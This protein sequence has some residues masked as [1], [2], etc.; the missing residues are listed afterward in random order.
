MRMRKKKHGAER[1]EKCKAVLA[2][3]C[4]FPV[5]DARFDFD[6]EAPLWLE[7]GAGK[8]GF[9]REMAARNPDVCFYALERSADCVVLAAEEAVRTAEQ[10]PTDNLRFVVASADTLAEHFAEGSIDRIYLNFSD[11]WSK[12][13]YYKR[14][15]TYRG[16]L[17]MYARLLRAGGLLRFKT[18]NVG[19]FDFTLEELAALGYTPRIVTRDL[20]ASCYKEGNVMTEYE[21]R[22]VGQGVPICMLEV[23][24]RNTQE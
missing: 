18:D 6:R 10:R 21:A 4:D 24:L 23:E 22:F 14:R 7:I 20:H 3:P 9:A 15:L 8:G 19:L 5:E 16:Y 11:P 17:T 13:G 1:L 12:K 2:K